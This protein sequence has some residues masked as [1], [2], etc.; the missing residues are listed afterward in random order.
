MLLISEVNNSACIS[1]ARNA[2]N[3]TYGKANFYIEGP[4]SGGI[5]EYKKQIVRLRSFEYSVN[6][7]KIFGDL[8]KFIEI[9]FSDINETSVKEIVGFI[10]DNCTESLTQFYLKNCDGLILNEFTRP[11]P[12]VTK[13]SFLSRT[14]FSARLAN[15]LD[16][17]FPKLTFLDLK[18]TNVSDWELIGGHFPYLKILI[19]DFPVPN[20]IVY[21]DIG[22]L[23]R[24]SRH[25][26]SLEINYI[27]LDM[28]KVASDS[29]PNLKV[30]KVFN[31]LNKAYDNDEIHFSNVSQLH[32]NSNENN[33]QIPEKL[34]FTQL[35]ELHLTISSDFT[36]SWIKFFKHQRNKTIYVC[37][38]SFDILTDRHLVAIAESQSNI[39]WAD[40]SIHNLTPITVDAISKFIEKSKK[41]FLVR[42]YGALI[43]VTQ[44]KIL[45]LKLAHDW[46]IDGGE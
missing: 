11:F 9:S 21:P 10:N 14:N 36:D 4:F 5:Y 8:M 41:L 6:T 12:S 43:N 32:L 20:D 38:L 33:P 30:L 1:E 44:R 2:F 3:R 18:I 26:Y 22:N 31:I 45:E 39:K 16:Q 29:L 17:I 46:M 7:L 24:N 19:I 23:F 28:L 40:I 42:F 27:S 35:H 25:I 15:K 37:E 34:V 13:A